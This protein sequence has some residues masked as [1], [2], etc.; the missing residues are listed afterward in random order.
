MMSNSLYEIKPVVDSFAF[1]ENLE[2]MLIY[3]DVLDYYPIV[4]CHPVVPNSC[5][6][7]L[8]I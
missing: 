8:L 5:I 3:S 7:H 1:A 4:D 2:K 6:N